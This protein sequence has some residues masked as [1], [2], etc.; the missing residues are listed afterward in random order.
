M[1][2]RGL[3]RLH[4]RFQAAVPKIEAA[5]R[6]VMEGYARQVVAQMK[7]VAP[8]EDGALRDSI[9][10]TWGAAPA[11]SIAIASFSGGQGR[12]SLRITI[13]AGSSAT[14]VTNSRGV[15]FQNAKL[16]EFGT[17]KMPATPY[18]FPVWRANRNRIRA[19]IARAAR[20]AWKDV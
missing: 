19:G 4:R 12:S 5:V 13:Y 3:D 6:P 18:F 8:F 10:W 17:K 20:K 16:Q 7:A 2:L 11:G 15:E 1:T 14:I 9:G